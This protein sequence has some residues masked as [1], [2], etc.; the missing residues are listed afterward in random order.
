MKRTLLTMGLTVFLVGFVSAPGPSPA[1]F[2]T[3]APSPPP[4]LQAEKEQSLAITH[5]PYLQLPT[6]TSMAIVW[7]TNKICVSRVEYGRAKSL[8]LTAI[9]SRHG[10][11]DNNK[12]SHIIRLTS[13]KPGQNYF[14]RVVSREFLGYKTQDSVAFGSTVT[15]PIYSFK[16]L[17]EKKQSFSFSMVSDMHERSAELEEMMAERAWEGIDFAVFNGDMVNDLMSPSQL[18]S[19]VLDASI[20]NFAK[21]KPLIYVRGNHEMRGSCARNFSDYIPAQ[22]CRTYYSFNH[23]PVHFIILD[24]GEDNPDSDEKYNGLGDF[25]RFR[26]EEAQW[27]RHD[28]ESPACT[29]AGFKI[30]VCHIPTWAEYDHGSR[31]VRQKFESLLNRAKLDLYLSGHTHTFTQ[32]NPIPGQNT[33]PIIIGAQDITT[34]VDVLPDELRVTAV[35]RGGTV[36]GRSVIKRK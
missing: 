13:L 10:L 23:G 30:A 9:S 25:D 8:G 3:Q 21:E 2:H 18:F 17:D 5:G 29:G 33:F 6:T 19:G 27:L 24:C 4:P 14:Y 15:S 35:R 31:E 1:F 7:Q 12:T 28:L 32:I 36:V 16:T 20:K 22:E 26:T 11:I 34:R